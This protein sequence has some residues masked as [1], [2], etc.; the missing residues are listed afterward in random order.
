LRKLIGEELKARSSPKIAKTSP[1][2]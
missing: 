2:T 1:N